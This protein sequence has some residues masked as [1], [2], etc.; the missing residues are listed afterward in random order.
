MRATPESF[1]TLKSGASKPLDTAVAP[2]PQVALAVRIDLGETSTGTEGAA[3]ASAPAAAARTV[4]AIIIP[5]GI[6]SDDRY[7]S[8]SPE[9]KVAGSSPVSGTSGAV[10]G[11]REGERCVPC[12]LR[13]RRAGSCS[14]GS[15]S[16]VSSPCS[17]P[18]AGARRR[19]PHR[20]PCA[21]PARTGPT[22]R[23][24][25]VSRSRS[26]GS[27]WQEP[28]TRSRPELTAPAGGAARA[29]AAG[30]GEALGACG[31]R[32]GGGLGGGGRGHGGEL[33]RRVRWRRW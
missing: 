24:A 21:D 7:L 5:L 29:A 4:V 32:R 22:P 14:M 19:D 10:A 12:G 1:P 15:T 26:P 27:G 25:G 28:L 30:G 2:R 11:A 13:S 31:L 33:L 16:N 17:T 23:A 6:G 9:P 8:A 3:S 20:A 18:R